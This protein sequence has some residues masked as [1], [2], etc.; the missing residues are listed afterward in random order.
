MS[1]TPSRCSA[2][3]MRASVLIRNLGIRTLTTSSLKRTIPCNAVSEINPE[4]HNNYLQ[5]REEHLDVL[6]RDLPLEG[7]QPVGLVR[8]QNEHG[9]ALLR[10]RQFEDAALHLG[11]VTKRQR[12]A[13]GH[14]RDLHPV[15][16]GFDWGQSIDLQFG[17]DCVPVQKDDQIMYPW[18]HLATTSVVGAC[19]GDGGES[20]DARDLFGRTMAASAARLAGSDLRR[21][22]IGAWRQRQIM[23]R[24]RQSPLLHVGGT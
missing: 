6:R 21:N 4:Q 5:C 24:R 23:R 18:H 22:D 8:Q 3:V 1:V 15:K 2:S 19:N 9:D 11:A 20:V 14:H 7:G 16:Q 17:A 10:E 12:E 13:A